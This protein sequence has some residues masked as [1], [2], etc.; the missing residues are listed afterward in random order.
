M[1]D[2]L[3]LEY[4]RNLSLSRLGDEKP[5][6]LWVTSLPLPRGAGQAWS[7]NG[8][9]THATPV[10]AWPGTPSP[11]PRR[12]VLA[13]DAGGEAPATVRLAEGGAAPDAAPPTAEMITF[14]HEDIAHLGQFYWE[15]SL[16]KIA[17]GGHRLELAMGMRVKGEVHWWEACN[18]VVRAQSPACLEIEMGGA[19][20]WELTTMEEIA[21]C[22]DRGLFRLIHVHNWLNGHIYAR[23]HANGV[24]EIYAHH[25]NSMFVDD[26]GDLHDAVPVLG[27][28]T[29]GVDMGALCGTWDG[30]RRNLRLGGIAFDFT[31]VARLA[32]PEKPGRVDM[33]DDFLV[34][35]PYLG[36]EWHGGPFTEGRLGDPWFMKAEQQIIPRGFARTLRFSASLNPARPP[37]VA[38]YL[39][40]AWWYGACEEF[41]PRPLLPVNNLFDATLDSARGWIHKYMIPAGY[42]EGVLP[43]QHTGDPAERATPGAEGDIPGEMFQMAYRTGDPVDYDCAMR[44]C[45]AFLDVMVDHAVKRVRMQGYP[46]PTGAMPLARMQSGIFAWLETGDPYCINTAQAVMDAAYWWHKN[47]WPRRAVGRDARFVHSLVLLYRYMNDE[48]SLI[49]ARDV[50]ADV[51]AAQW[52]DG[53][54]GDQGGGAGIH[55]SGAYLAK[56]WMGWLATMGILD[57]LEVVG[58]DPEAEAIVRRFVDWLESER[59]PRKTKSGETVMG[60]TYQHNFQGKPLADYPMPERPT[61]GMHLFHMEYMARL[62]PWMS[63]KTGDPKYFEMYMESYQGYGAAR[64]GS[65]WDGPSLFLFL[66]WLQARLWNARLTPDGVEVHPA[67]FGPRTPVAGIIQTPDG[68]LTLTWK[69]PGELEEPEGVKCRVVLEGLTAV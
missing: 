43:N 27:L 32:T 64:Q 60:W 20:P 16:L 15:R 5:A 6:G 24:C 46:P 13:A 39:A 56:P 7:L 26:G 58:E 42:E 41:L 45:Y 12:L 31:D 1:S 69:A 9:A 18:L 25:I 30:T 38:R 49:R 47:S 63:F 19:I 55:G 21:A 35:Q 17:W 36:M 8:R 51:G 34:L 65:Y 3:L 62:L 23:L 61:P 44:S 50:I 59:A 28:R 22:K 67:Y 66:P 48:R 14:A 10:G 68:P 33:A 11:G 29:E 4:L 53:S 40:P 54:F 37:R 52:E 57:Y 2:D